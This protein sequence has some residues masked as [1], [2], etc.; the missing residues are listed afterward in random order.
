MLAE[1]FGQEWPSFARESKQKEKPCFAAADRMCKVEEVILDLVSRNDGLLGVRQFH[2]VVRFGS[3][4]LCLV[5]SPFSAIPTFPESLEV[6]SFHTKE[7]G[8]LAE[9]ACALRLSRQFHAHEIAGVSEAIADVKAT[10]AVC[11]VT[12]VPARDLRP[13]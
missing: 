7:K 10:G 6:S 3:Q 5:F 4:A 13:A 11:G 2:S 9:P 8:G 12:P 1:L